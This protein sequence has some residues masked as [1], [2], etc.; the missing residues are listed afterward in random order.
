MWPRL[1]CIRYLMVILIVIIC[2]GVGCREVVKYNNDW[3]DNMG[4]DGRRDDWTEL[5]RHFLVGCVDVL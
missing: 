4:I 3:A 5:S 1:L 2:A